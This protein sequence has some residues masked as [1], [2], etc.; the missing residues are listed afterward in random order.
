[1]WQ[2]NYVTVTLER[3]V[4]WFRSVKFMVVEK[5]PNRGEPPSED[6]VPE[7]LPWMMNQMRM[8]Q[9]PEATSGSANWRA[10]P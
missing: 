10:E 1:L 5:R 7:I 9:S 2:R 3:R 4:G 6:W 8:S